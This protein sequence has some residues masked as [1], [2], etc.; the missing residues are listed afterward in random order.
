MNTSLL[1][2]AVLLVSGA[3][4]VY[5]GGSVIASPDA[6]YAA[7]GISLQGD[8]SLSNELRASG[9]SVLMLGLLI[10]SGLVISRF[11]LTSTVLAGAMFLAFG[12][13][14]FLSLG[15]DGQPDAGLVTAMIA[16]L[17]IGLASLAALIAARRTA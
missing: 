3:T 9:G 1:H 2:K 6:F 7:Y 8:V 5:I 12:A 11:A 17:V 14:R 16:E 15:L 10:L 4:A 13:T